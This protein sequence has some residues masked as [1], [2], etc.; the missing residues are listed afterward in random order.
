MPLFAPVSTQHDFATCERCG[1]ATADRP[2][3]GAREDL[4]ALQHQIPL[5]FAK[6]IEP[7]HI[8]VAP[9]GSTLIMSTSGNELLQMDLQVHVS[10]PHAVSE[11]ALLNSNLQW[12]VNASIGCTAQYWHI[13][14]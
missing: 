6:D 3:T 4:F 8:S 12:A 11:H 5:L 13:C 1:T 14:G 9:T 10:S 7:L 2:Q